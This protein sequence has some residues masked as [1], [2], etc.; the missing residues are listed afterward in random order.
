MT[1]AAGPESAKDWARWED[2]APRRF[3]FK[4]K[5]DC[6]TAGRAEHTPKHRH[7]HAS[8]YRCRKRPKVRS[9]TSSDVPI[10]EIP[11][12]ALPPDVAFRES[13]FD[14][15]GDD[16]GAAYWEGVYGQP[17][18]NYPNHYQNEETGELERMNDDEYAQ[19]VRRRMWEKSWEGIEA[20][21]EEQR[22][23]REGERRNA[24]T[25]SRARSGHAKAANEALRVDVE[26]EQSLRRGDQRKKDKHWRALWND[27]LRRWDDLQAIVRERQHGVVDGEQ[28][29]LRNKIAWPIESG[30]RKDVNND[31]LERFIRS[32][33]TSAID[34]RSQHAALLQ[35]LKIERIRWHPDKI[36]HR[37]ASMHIDENTMRGATA[38]FQTF[39]RMWN[40]LRA[41]S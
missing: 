2:D 18:H 32:G 31:A 19:Y 36:Q 21:R 22:R 41:Q 37:F 13:L 26:V 4:A 40:E 20:K 11:G 29:Y 30:Q 3:R 8:S 12:A 10:H 7:H 35:A 28:M 25:K 15:M 6:A 16:E 5:E 39:D 9:S 14:A 17:I 33:T 34:G 38:V 24:E 23:E 1:S 27:Y